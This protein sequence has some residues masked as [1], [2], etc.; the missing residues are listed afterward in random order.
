MKNRAEAEVFKFTQHRNMELLDFNVESQDVQWTGKE[1]EVGQGQV[2][3][4]EQHL[5]YGARWQM[6]VFWMWGTE[7]GCLVKPKRRET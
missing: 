2:R 1:V 7:A 3:V 4:R 6:A 5:P